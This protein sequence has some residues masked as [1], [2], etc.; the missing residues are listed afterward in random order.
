VHAIV[1]DRKQVE[2]LEE[3]AIARCV[4]HGQTEQV[5]VYS[6]VMTETKN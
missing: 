5:K 4:R 6:F 2:R 3:Q 1:G